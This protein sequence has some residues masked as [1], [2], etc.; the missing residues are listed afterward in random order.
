MKQNGSSTMVMRSLLI[1]IPLSL[2]TGALLAQST[3]TFAGRIQQIMSRPVYAHAQFG[4]EVYSLDSAKPVFELNS[5]KLF[6][7]GS[8]TKLFTEGT[9]LELLGGD[10][11]FH[12]RIYRTGPVKK[13]G[14]LDGDLILVASGDPN[15]SGRIQS[16]RDSGI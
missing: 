10:Y 4:I 1:L 9:A 5:Q 3:S 13:N 6:V 14:T 16:E 15:L 12:T 2:G 8:T 11:R 7:P